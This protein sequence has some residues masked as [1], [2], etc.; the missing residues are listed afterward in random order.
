MEGDRPAKRIK[1]DLV[2]T[3]GNAA[4]AEVSSKTAECNLPNTPNPSKGI[5][6][7]SHKTS[8]K[9]HKNGRAK[10]KVSEANNGKGCVRTFSQPSVI[11]TGDKGIF[12][13]SDKGCEKKALLEIHDILQEILESRGVGADGKIVP[14]ESNDESK[15]MDNGS[16]F[17]AGIP[18]GI[19]AEIASELAELRGQAPA[20]LGATSSA[21]SKPMQLITLD[22]P[23]VSFL[24]LPAQSSI[25]PVELVHRLCLEAADPES[26]QRSRYVKR[27][28]PISCLAK[29]LK[30]GL[31]TVCENVLPRHFGTSATGEIKS[32]TFAIRPTIRE[33]VQVDR[34]SVIRLVASHVQELGGQ[35][36]RV[37]LKNYE[38]GVIVEVYR[39]WVGMCVVDNVNSRDYQQGYEQLK[40]FN[41]AELYVKR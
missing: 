27:L 20:D 1:T 33:N 21:T 8:S 36:H 30:Q 3:P 35:S 32:T 26:R 22:I 10:Q 25:D 38:K 19:E 7:N 6:K 41:V 12:V 40:R 4:T 37:D 23:C 14:Q 9:R 18:K 15:R 24:R 11:C 34:D 28:T 31:E 17:N 16:D 5:L 2:S 13:T 39:G 29:T